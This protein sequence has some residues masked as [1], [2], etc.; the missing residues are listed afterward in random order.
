MTKVDGRKQRNNQP[1][2]GAVKGDVGGGGDD[3]SN[4]A[5]VAVVD[6]RD[7]RLEMTKARAVAQ[8]QWQGLW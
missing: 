3:N 8:G 1:T 5:V 7:W 6:D 4:G 2:T